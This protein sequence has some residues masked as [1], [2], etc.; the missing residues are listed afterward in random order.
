MSFLL[1]KG[2][3][4]NTKAVAG[5]TVQRWVDNKGMDFISGLLIDRITDMH[6]G[7][8]LRYTK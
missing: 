6:V 3:A 2:H 7:K 4:W 1:C 5:R 8:I